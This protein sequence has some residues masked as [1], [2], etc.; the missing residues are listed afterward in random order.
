[1]SAW[2]RQM[3]GAEQAASG[4]IVRRSVHDVDRI[5]GLDRLIEEARTRGFHV[6]ETGDQ[7]IV[8]CNQEGILIHC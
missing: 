8:I 1:M 2:I 3:F 6:I 4:G 5:V 7:V